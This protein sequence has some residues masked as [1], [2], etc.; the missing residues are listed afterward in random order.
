ME[1]KPTDTLDP[2]IFQRNLDALTQRDPALANRLSPLAAADAALPPLVRT[3]DGHLN[4]RL[5]RPDGPPAWFGR[6][7]IP[8]VRAEALLAQFHAGGGNVL[9]PGI[10]E[11]TEA[12]LLTQRLARHQVVFIWESDIGILHL[13]IRLRDFAEP[14]L[15]ERLVFLV[16]PVSG[17]TPVLMDWVRSHP[18]RS[19]P[20]RLL[21]W[22]WQSMS[23]I[24]ACRSAVESA[25]Q[26]SQGGPP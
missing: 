10:G 11:G 2:S 25:Y 5:P 23:E 20:T 16:C 12:R 6:S 26:Q 14:I 1:H 17:L 9:L 3:R 8:G 7:S 4:F 15:A 13:A 21:M 22:P 18:G 24:S 19:C